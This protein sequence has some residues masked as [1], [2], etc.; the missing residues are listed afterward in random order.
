M[1]P[2]M[3]F[4]MLLSEAQTG[5]EAAASALVREYE[6]ELRRYV[7]LKLTHPGVRRFVDSL[8]VCQSVLAVFFVH[9]R[10]GRLEIA[11]SRQLVRLLAVMAEN[12]VR[13]KV[14]RHR[15]V[16]RGGGMA[17][18]SPYLNEV[19]PPAPASDP[20]DLVADRELVRVIR[21]RLP[22]NARPAVDRWMAGDGWAEIAAAIGGTP[23]GIRKQV[24]RSLDR[25]ARELGLIEEIS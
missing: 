20:A 1:T 23:E 6:S 18:A 21:E 25:A 16:R 13:D 3:S 11:N 15:A 17:D 12:K 5:D 24:T 22:E 14:R 8:D 4:R 9:L 7:R 2:D 10:E 19:D